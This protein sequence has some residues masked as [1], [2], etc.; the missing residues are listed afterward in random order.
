MYVYFS[1]KEEK[2]GGGRAR[3]RWYNQRGGRGRGGCQRGIMRGSWAGRG[4]PGRGRGRGRGAMWGRIGP[5]I[6][7]N[8]YFY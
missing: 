3:A 2:R 5:T 6:I 7:K 4:G 8:V 1:D